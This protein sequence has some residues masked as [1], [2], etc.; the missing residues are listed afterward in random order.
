V[1]MTSSRARDPNAKLDLLQTNKAQYVA[2]RE[3]VLLRVAPATYLGITGRG[4]P[5][6]EAFQ[7]AIAALYGVAFTVKMASKLAGRDYGVCKLEGLLWADSECSLTTEPKDQWSWRL[8][9]R[10]PDFIGKPEIEAVRGR[11]AERATTHCSSRS[12]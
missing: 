4:A 2:P 6:G 9:I 3:P 7:Q 11:L 5:G 1:S 10:T 12:R 8:L